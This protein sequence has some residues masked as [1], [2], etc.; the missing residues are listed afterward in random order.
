MVSWDLYKKN[1][2]APKV[3]SELLV[4]KE[5]EPKEIKKVDFHSQSSNKSLP[6]PSSTGWSRPCSLHLE[7]CTWGSV[8]SSSLPFGVWKDSGSLGINTRCLLW[9]G[10]NRIS[11]GKKTKISLC[12]GGHSSPWE[13]LGKADFWV[14]RYSLFLR[15]TLCW[16][17]MLLQAIPGLFLHSYWCFWEG[18]WD[19]MLFLFV[20]LFLTIVYN[21]VPPLSKA[22]SMPPCSVLY[23]DADDSC[24]EGFLVWGEMGFLAI[25]WQWGAESTLCNPAWGMSENWAS[26][27]DSQ[28]STFI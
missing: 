28:F 7:V 24:S 13:G 20:C 19:T 6:F 4:A 11:P 23:Q 3:E 26:N 25:A 14:G 15:S 8:N 16:T 12:H 10:Q 5:L 22:G 27:H 18:L 1:K 9:E 2:K 17:T 21:Y